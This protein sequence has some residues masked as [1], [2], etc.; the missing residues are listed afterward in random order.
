MP[1]Y[2][3][4]GINL[5]QLRIGA[6]DMGNPTRPG[7]PM[8][9]TEAARRLHVTQQHL[10]NVENGRHQAGPKLKASMATLYSCSLAVVYAAAATSLATV[11]P[12]RV[13]RKHDS[14]KNQ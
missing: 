6:D 12:P 13:R 14:S 4:T 1:K 7:G 9:A 11:R 8:T 5:K 2:R 3:Q 10:S